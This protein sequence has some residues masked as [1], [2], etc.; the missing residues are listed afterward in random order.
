M[1]KSMKQKAV[2]VATQI[3]VLGL[4]P[5]SALAAIFRLEEATVADINNAFDSGALTAERLIQLYLNRIEA[6]EYDKQGPRLNSIISINPNA[7]QIA[8]DLDLERQTT[9]PRS[10]LHGVP[11]LLKDNFDT[12]DMPT[13][14]GSIVLNGSIP[15]DDASSVNLLRDAGAIILGK[16]NMREFAARGGL[17]V[18][19]TYGGETRNPYNLNRNASGSSG[20]TGAAIAAN[21]ATIGTGSDTGGSIRGPASFN[22]LVGV[23]PTRGLI[24]LDGIIPFALSRDGIGPMARNVTDAVT[25]L[26]I[27][28]EFDPNN[29]SF[30]TPIPAPLVEKDKIYEDYTQFLNSNALEG[31]RIGVGRVWF[32]GDPEV[33]RLIE[34]SLQTMRELGATT[35]DLNFDNDFLTTMIDASRSIGLAEFP[36][37]L[38]A[39]LATLE[40]GYPKTLEDIIA[41]AQS[42]EFADLVPPAS[43]AGLNNIQAYGGLTN[44]EYIDVV[45]SK[46]PLIRERLLEIMDSNDVDTIVFPTTR[47]FA[48]PFVGT[49]DPTF[50]EILPAPPIRGVEIASLAGFSDITV[51]AG[52]SED[53]LPITIS[54]TGRPYSEPTLIGLAYSYEQATMLRGPSPLVPPLPGEEFEYEPVPEPP[55][56]IALIV[57]GFAVLGLKRRHRRNK[58]KLDPQLN[59]T[60]SEAASNKDN[61][62]STSLVVL[63]Y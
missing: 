53:G 4:L 45:E 47:T 10:P 2:L 30:Q 54:F 20:G 37:Q 61:N 62:I 38:A 22:G 60:P 11:V 16:T 33:D 48:S 26:G 24:S 50:V 59:V 32:G 25:T 35:V 1:L 58:G 12:F 44:P 19:P 40:E 56:T 42:P 8:R 55:A 23:R 13:T 52:F 41:I 51:P 7:S 3:V 46:L 14:A 34:G 6:Y 49:T 43:L 31:A 29:P 9:G 27:M 5:G 15:P 63:K 39:Y 21:L 57:V 28:A 17:G 36:P 18:F